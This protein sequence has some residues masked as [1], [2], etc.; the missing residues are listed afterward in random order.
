MLVLF[1]YQKLSCSDR[2]NLQPSDS[3]HQ[4]PQ[5]AWEAK[6]EELA[7]RGMSDRATLWTFTADCLTLKG[8]S[9]T[10]QSTPRTWSDSKLFLRLP[11]ASRLPSWCT[12]ARRWL[13]FKHVQKKQ[14][15]CFHS[16]PVNILTYML[17]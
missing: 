3:I 1:Y 8:C 6:T 15:V 7:G 14:T 5:L 2:L 10:Q 16:R 12:L 17:S 13:E 9:S 4:T 11:Q